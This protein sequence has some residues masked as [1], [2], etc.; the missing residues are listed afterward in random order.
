MLNLISNGDVCLKTFTCIRDGVYCCSFQGDREP[1]MVFSWERKHLLKYDNTL[2]FKPF[3]GYS[4]GVRKIIFIYH[5]VING[6]CPFLNDMGLCTIHEFKPLS[7]RMFP[8]ILGLSDNT[9]RVS[10][11]C[12]II[13]EN[14]E[15]Y[16]GDPSV[17]FPNEFTHAVKTYIIIKIIEEM[18]DN[19]GWSRILMDGSGFNGELIDIDDIIDIDDLL[20][21]IDDN[22]L[23]HR[24]K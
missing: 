23:K 3:Y 5:W 20:K 19:L 11:A 4:D 10:L 18:A 8:L 17:V 12:K 15:E 2:V 16:K 9:L 21:Q 7:C 13:A 6:R 1:V 14:P 22:L 24:Q